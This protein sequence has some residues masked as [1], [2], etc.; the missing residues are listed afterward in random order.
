MQTSTLRSN[1]P[2][3]R[4]HPAAP[5]AVCPA[6]GEGFPSPADGPRTAHAL[7]LVSDVDGTL[8]DG[9]GRLPAPPAELRRRLGE[10]CRHAAAALGRAIP[11]TG[12]A[13]LALASSRT[14]RE[15][16]VLQR[17]LGL[18]GPC[19]AEDGA[20]IAVERREGPAPTGLLGEPPAPARLERHGRR[21]LA[22]FPVGARAAA[23]RVALAPALADTAIDVAA[24][25][26]AQQRALGFS[27]ARARRAMA[28][29]EAS[30]LLDL[31]HA[32]PER[33]AAL[34]DAARRAGITVRRGGRWHTAVAHA[35]KGDALRTLRAHLA[36][37]PGGPPPW[38]VAIGNEENDESLL[39]EADLAVVIRN[40]G[41]GH[42]PAL[43]AI[44]GARL[45][46]ATGPLGWLELLDRLP[47]WAAEA[48]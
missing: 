6:A 1:A 29:R 22:V 43:A 33:R 42:H 37:P 35:T 47:Q 23:L 8:L 9:A 18:P 11:D 4:A 36:T 46:E 38:T 16:T 24:L 45:L 31:S 20:V 40:P 10:A 30:L 48:A 32:Q 2:G 41:R 17:A 12:A 14:V 21:A 44:P 28:R 19:L 25:P 39:Q 3:H 13:T 15:L 5:V 26:A 34:L 7:L 27:P